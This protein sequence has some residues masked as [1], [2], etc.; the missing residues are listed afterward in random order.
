MIKTFLFTITA[1]QIETNSQSISQNHLKPDEM[2]SPKQK[3]QATSPNLPLN[4]VTIN[5][6]EVCI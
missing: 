2:M 3:H 1:S 6:D 4:E 5:E